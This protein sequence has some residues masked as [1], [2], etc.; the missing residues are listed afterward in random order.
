LLLAENK[1]VVEEGWE[2]KPKC[3]LQILFEFKLI[4]D[5]FYKNGPS[6]VAKMQKQDAFS[7]GL[8]CMLCWNRV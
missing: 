4:V 7:Q 5:T 1:P 3:I 6:T 2:G 8:H